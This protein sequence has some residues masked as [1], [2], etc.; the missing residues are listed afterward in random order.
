MSNTPW[1]KCDGVVKTPVYVVVAGLVNAQRTVCT[2]AL[3]VCAYLTNAT[4]PPTEV[5]YLAILAN[6]STFY[7]LVKCGRQVRGR[8]AHGETQLKRG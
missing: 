8:I 3:G 5:L 2:L 6:K 7:V 1:V 4:R